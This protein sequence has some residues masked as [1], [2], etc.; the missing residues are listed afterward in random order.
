METL[1]S[2][3]EFL[4]NI[5][6]Q[7]LSSGLSLR[8]FAQL[9]HLDSVGDLETRHELIMRRIEEVISLLDHYLNDMSYCLEVKEQYSVG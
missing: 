4:A 7:L 6:G 1:T 5:R 2:K 3:K 9:E 8:Q